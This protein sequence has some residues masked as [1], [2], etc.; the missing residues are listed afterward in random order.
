MANDLRDEIFVTIQNNQYTA[1]LIVE[2]T[3]VLSGI[4]R[5]QELLGE[6]SISAVFHKQDRDTVLAGENVLTLAGTPKEIAIAEEFIIG[7]LSKSSG[8]ATAARQAVDMAG[9]MRIVSGAWKKMPPEIK[10]IV[11]EAV[12][13]GGA[14]FRVV[15]DPFLY[16]DKNFVC[17]LGGI[18]ET[19]RAVENR[20]ELKCI[21]IKG[22]TGDIAEEAALAAMNG[23]GV[24]MLDTGNIEELRKVSRKLQEIGYR[25][26]VRLAF[27]KGI[28][29]QDIRKLRAEDIDI[30]D[31][32]VQI[33]DAPLL[34]MKLDV[35]RS[36]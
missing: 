1:Q 6:R 21:Q 14:Y 35:V 4:Q 7:M 34:D 13:H 23:A 15:D 32:G 5:L 29:L 8:I 3:G 30:L 12:S 36:S 33:I 16:L 28:K 17:M 18:K 19:L 26:K 22:H 2:R 10:F 20:P 24:I 27:A 9:K 31:I 11:R 25:S